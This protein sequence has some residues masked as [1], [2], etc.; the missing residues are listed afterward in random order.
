MLLG[1]WVHPENASYILDIGTGTGVLA[2]MV[3]GWSDTSALIFYHGL[4]RSVEWIMAVHLFKLSHLYLSSLAF[5][6]HFD[7]SYVPLNPAPGVTLVY[8]HLAR[9]IPQCNSPTITLVTRP[10]VSNRR[11][12]NARYPVQ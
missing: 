6:C 3:R 11:Q 4:L 12:H 9:P 2:L 1:S 7:P 5:F 10:V 8:I